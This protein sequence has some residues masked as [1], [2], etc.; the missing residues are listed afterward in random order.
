MT[1][2]YIIALWCPVSL[3]VAFLLGQIMR[4]A[5]FGVDEEREARLVVRHGGPALNRVPLYPCRA[6]GCHAQLGAKEALAQ[7]FMCGR[8]HANRVLA[9]WPGRKEARR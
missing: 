7:G 9:S 5:N 3:G 2:L 8:H 6:R 4:P 1:W